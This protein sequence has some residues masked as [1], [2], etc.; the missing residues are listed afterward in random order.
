MR[1]THHSEYG[2]IKTI[3][4]KHVTDSFKNQDRISKQWQQLNFLGEPR[5][6]K[7]IEEYGEFEKIIQDTRADISYFDNDQSLT[8][9]S[10]YCRDSFIATDFG[11]II[12]SM[13]KRD[14]SEETQS[15]ALQYKIH[16]I[17]ILGEIQPPGKVE[18]GDV[19]WLNETTLAVG[20]SYRTNLEG[21]HQLRSFL[22]PHGINVIKVDLPHFRGPDDVFHLMSI[23]SPID[24][25]L[26]VVY[27]PLMSVAFRNTLL[28]MGFDFVEVPDEEFEAMGCNVLALAPRRCVMVNGCPLTH[29]HLEQKGVTVITYKGEEISIKGGG[30]PT[31]LTRPM[32]RAL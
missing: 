16:G 18:G 14:R 25:D 11:M 29:L 26:L 19:C 20:H 8:L 30:G 28:D 3:Y 22:Q 17:R 1:M 31:C 7:A 12:C 6:E 13:G 21:I 27:S 10:I 2:L 32:L 9:D 15:V 24:K 4:L 5:F 23:L